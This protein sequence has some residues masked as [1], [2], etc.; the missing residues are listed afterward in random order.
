[1]FKISKFSVKTRK[2]VKSLLKLT[3]ITRKTTLLSSYSKN[4]MRQNAKNI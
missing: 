1:M 4:L 3:N 2:G